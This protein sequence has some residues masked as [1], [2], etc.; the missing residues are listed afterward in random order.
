MSARVAAKHIPLSVEQQPQI[1]IQQT[2]NVGLYKRDNMRTTYNDNKIKIIFRQT[3]FKYLG[4][5]FYMLA[6]LVFLTLCR[7]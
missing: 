1:I 3:K 4:L 6:C 5:V 2:E 7:F